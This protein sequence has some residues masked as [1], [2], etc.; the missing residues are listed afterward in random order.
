MRYIK[1]GI[2]LATVGAM[3]GGDIAPYYDVDITIPGENGA[4]ICPAGS[5]LMW[6][7]SEFDDNSDG[8]YKRERS[9]SK[10][11]SHGYAKDY[12]DR[13][14]YAG[15]SDWRL[16]TSDEMMEISKTKGIFKDNRGADFWTSTP[17]EQ[18][19]YYVVYTVDGYRY[20]RDPKQSN[21]IRCVR[22]LTQ[23]DDSTKK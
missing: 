3:A 7:N 8:A 18:N 5:R 1:I 4:N 23:E 11:G 6:Q 15:Y 22:C 12:C 17:A 10:A 14:V 20:A 16:P 21:Y 2:F 19:K 9:L 13:L